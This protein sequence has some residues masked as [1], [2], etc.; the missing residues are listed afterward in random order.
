MSLLG[1]AYIALLFTPYKPLAEER[2]RDVLTVLLLGDRTQRR[3]MR[4]IADARRPEV[5]KV[6]AGQTQVKGQ[7]VKTGPPPSGTPVTVSGS[8]NKKTPITMT[9]TFKLA[10]GQLERAEASLKRS[11]EMLRR[12]NIMLRQMNERLEEEMER[13]RN[14][15]GL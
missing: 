6:T 9:I 11:A 2:P 1:I 14:R 12:Q 4:R 10:P 8:L 15:R 5:K 13:Q 7:R 3:Q